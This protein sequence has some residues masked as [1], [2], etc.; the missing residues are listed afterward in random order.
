MKDVMFSFAVVLVIGL[1]WHVFGDQLDQRWRV[2]APVAAIMLVNVLTKLV[3]P[4]HLILRKCSWLYLSLITAQMTA[5]AALLGDFSILGY[6]TIPTLIGLVLLYWAIHV[7]LGP[8]YVDD[9][10]RSRS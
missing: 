5:M 10:G 2:V 3:W 6:W 7:T 1:C 4:S 8:R 9:E